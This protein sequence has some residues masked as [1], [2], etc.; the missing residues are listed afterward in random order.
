MSGYC[1]KHKKQD[2]RVRDKRR[3]TP[4]QRGYS[5][6]WSLYSKAF[7]RNPDNVFCKLQLPGCTNLAGCVDHK[8]PPDGPDDPRFW[9]PNNHQ[10]ACIHCNSVKGH[11]MIKG[12]AEPFEGG[13][14]DGGY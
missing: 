12:E 9:D 6:R 8:D 10:A 1:D 3:G 5:Y 4:H 2:Q 11:R 14:K 7:L 13:T